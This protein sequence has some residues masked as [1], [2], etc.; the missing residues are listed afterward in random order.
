MART[1]GTRRAARA[2]RRRAMPVRRARAPQGRRPPRPSWHLG[3]SRDSLGSSPRAPS[4]NTARALTGAVAAGTQARKQAGRR[5][6]RASQRSRRPRPLAWPVCWLQMRARALRDKS[7]AL[8]DAVVRNVIME[9]EVGAGACARGWAQQDTAAICLPRNTLDCSPCEEAAGA[10]SIS[11]REDRF[12]SGSN[13]KMLRAGNRV[14][15][16]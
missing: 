13:P 10:I 8:D 6:R 7:R 14:L 15:S 11:C 2:P 3:V 9:I 4:T 1:P 5:A 12:G 16:G